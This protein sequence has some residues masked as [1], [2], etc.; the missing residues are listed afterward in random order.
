MVGVVIGEVLPYAIGI[1]VSPIPIIAVILMLLAPRARLAGV[2][3]LAGWLVGLAVALGGLLA[4]G[5]ATALGDR[6]SDSGGTALLVAGGLLLVAAARQWRSRPGPG[7]EPS[8]PAW[9]R[10]ADAVTPVRAC[11]FGFVLALNPKNLLLA[12][13]AAVTVAQAGLD[14]GEGAAVIGGFV[15]VAGSSV[16]VP[17]LAYLAFGDRLREPLAR[18]RVW[19]Q[20]NNAAVMATLLLVLGVVLVGKGISALS[21]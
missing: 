13:G 7:E 12:L 15:L 2:G 16:L 3:F 10:A 19:L 4:I 17:V 5:S 21:L 14:D 1:A 8:L 18:L 20:A 9:L 6:G 11:G